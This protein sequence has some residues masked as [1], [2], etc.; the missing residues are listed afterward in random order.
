MRIDE[1]RR[2]AVSYAVFLAVAGV[3]WWGLARGLPRWRELAAVRDH[4]ARIEATTLEA[5][6]RTV[7]SG[8]RAIEDSISAARSRFAAT[9]ALVPDIGAG[10]GDGDVRRL[11]AALVEKS[12]VALRALEEGPGGREGALLV[13]SARVTAAGRYHDLGSWVSMV[14]ATRRLVQVKD[15]TMS[16]APEPANGGGQTPGAAPQGM[17]PV[18]LQATVRWFRRDSSAVAQDSTKGGQ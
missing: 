8:D 4:R 18:I 15:V 14:E 11:L 6:S 3:A 5:R 17:E 13:S 9:Q 1:A 7:R 12:G 16:A 2:R 10:E